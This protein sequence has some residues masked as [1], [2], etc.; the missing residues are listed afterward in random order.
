MASARYALLN[1]RPCLAKRSIF[2]VFAFL[3]PYNGRSLY[4]QSSAM[5]IRKLGCLAEAAISWA[6]KVHIKR[7]NMRNIKRELP[8]FV[9]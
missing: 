8:S 2:G 4:V 5:I 1:V 9:I 6:N 7:R 3:P